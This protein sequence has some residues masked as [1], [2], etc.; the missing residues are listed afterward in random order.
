[1]NI[2]MWNTINDALEGSELRHEKQ[3]VGNVLKFVRKN[4]V[5][6]SEEEARQR[7]EARDGEFYRSD[8]VIGATADGRQCS[9]KG[10]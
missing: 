9:N 10:K 6:I 2:S 8:D 5:D 7:F 4:S 3:T 1:M